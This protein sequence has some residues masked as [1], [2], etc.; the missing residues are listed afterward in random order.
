[1][2]RSGYLPEF[3]RRVIDLVEGGWK[4]AEVAIDE[5]VDLTGPAIIEAVLKMLSEGPCSMP[6][7]MTVSPVAETRKVS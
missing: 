4:V 2:A 1:M 7:S 5:I 6:I 3:R